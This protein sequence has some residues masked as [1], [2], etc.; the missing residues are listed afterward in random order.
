MTDTDASDSDS[1]SDSDSTVTPARRGVLMTIGELG[2]VLDGWRGVGTAE[3]TQ[4]WA[5]LHAD[6]TADLELRSL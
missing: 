1:D 5:V 3:E 4:I 6:D 2:Q